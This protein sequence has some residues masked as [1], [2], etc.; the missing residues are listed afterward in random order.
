MPFTY[1]FDFAFRKSISTKFE[2][3]KHY[4]NPHFCGMGS[5]FHI[6]NPNRQCTCPSLMF[7]FSVEDRLLYDNKMINQILR[8][9]PF[10]FSI[11]A[12][13]PTPRRSFSWGSYERRLLSFHGHNSNRRKVKKGKD[14][15]SG[16]RTPSGDHSDSSQRMRA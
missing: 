4:G 2:I 10:S 14:N 5:H 1:T 6:I 8:S 7:Q 12:L 9:S 13:V 16:R 15:E 3:L 11:A